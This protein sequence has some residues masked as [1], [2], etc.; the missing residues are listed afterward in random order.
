MDESDRAIG[1]FDSGVGGLTVA[2]ALKRKLPNEHIIYFGDLLHLPYGSK[3][4]RAVLDFTGAAV[5]FLMERAVKLI[6]I[7]CN[8]ATAIALEMVESEFDIPIIGVI[9]PGARTACNLSR[10]KRIGV[11]GTRRTIESEAYYETIKRYDPQ[12]TVIQKATP[13]LV[14]LIEEGW[15]DHKVLEIVL[16]EYLGDF[17]EQSVD[18]IVLGCTHYPLIKD[19]IQHILEGVRIVDSAEA[20]AEETAQKLRVQ[21]LF[22]RRDREGDYQIFLTDYN[23]IFKVMGEMILMREIGRI[24]PITLDWSEGKIVY[25]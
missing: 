22:T 1:V 3:S 13:L 6:V 17:I 10:N 12:M 5:R 21:D 14:P 18:T 7:A 20:S 15:K 4:S 8:T 19:E 23:E 2:A 25:R 11:I 16:S 9:E 24:K